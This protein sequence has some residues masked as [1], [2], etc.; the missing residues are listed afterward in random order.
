M[1][2][3]I[4]WTSRSF[5]ERE[6]NEKGVKNKSRFL[7]QNF[8][9]ITKRGIGGNNRQKRGMASGMRFEDIC[10]PLNNDSIQ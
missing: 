10:R 9:P 6:D 3:C 2:F 8:E 4:D 5:R 1:S 7:T